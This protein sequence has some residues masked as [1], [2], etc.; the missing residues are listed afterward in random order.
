MSNISQTGDQ[1]GRLTF[2]LS[3]VNLFK[4][5]ESFFRSGNVSK[6]AKIYHSNYSYELIPDTAIKDFMNMSRVT[7]IETGGLYICIFDKPS[8]Q[9]NYYLAGPREKI[10]IS[11]CGSIIASVRKLPIGMV[12][13]MGIPP[14]NFWELTGSKYQWHFS[15]AYKYV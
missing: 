1:F 9:G 4:S 8:Y 11:G 3:L 2:S 10:K 14:N 5:L 12:Q 6:T 15:D 13:R 7:S